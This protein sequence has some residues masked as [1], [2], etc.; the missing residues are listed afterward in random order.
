[1]YCTYVLFSQ[2]TGRYYIGSTVNLRNRLAEHNAGK[3]TSTKHGRPWL[4]VY[5]E[6]HDTLGQARQREQLIKSWKN[7]SYMITKLGIKP[8]AGER[9]DWHREGRGFESPYLHH[10]FRI[11]TRAPQ[12]PAVKTICYCFNYTDQDIIE[13]VRAHGGRSLIE[14]HITAEKR[15]GACDC[16]H[17]NPQKQ[18]CLADV[19]RVVERARQSLDG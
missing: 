19:H 12:V 4:L 6:E 16:E 2:K 10:L 18:W 5:S 15:R 9:P 3:T 1:M 7:Q 13:D 14:E 11:S 17:K 8:D